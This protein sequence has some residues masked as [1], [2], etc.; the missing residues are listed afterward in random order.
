MITTKFLAEL[1]FC[2]YDEENLMIS[3]ECWS[4]YEAA[5]EAEQQLE[6]EYHL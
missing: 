3:F 1:G 4:S 2:G 5:D 6:W